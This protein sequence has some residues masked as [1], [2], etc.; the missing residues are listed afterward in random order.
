MNRAIILLA[1][2][3]FISA[4][5][6]TGIYQT[7][8]NNE[9]RQAEN[10]RH[11]L[12]EGEEFLSHNDPS[13]VSKA[14]QIF[15]ELSARIEKGHRNYF[16]VNYNL[17]LALEKKGEKKRALEK[18]RE[19]SSFSLP[20]LEENRLRY[21]LGNI[22]LMMNQEEEGK[23]LLKSVLSNSSDNILR[24]K[25][26]AAI[27]DYYYFKRNYNRAR[28]NYVLALKE[29]AGNVK[30]RI[31]W[32]RTLRAE[33]KDWAA[34]EVFDEYLAHDSIL[35]P[36]KQKSVKSDYKTS[37]YERAR[38]L[39]NKN[40]IVSQL[41]ILIKPY[42]FLLVARLKKSHYT[43]WPKVLMLWDRLINPSSI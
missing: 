28:K 27:A 33:G 32:G 21:S 6:A 15:T 4:G 19:L 42:L 11:K 41:I 24:A 17:A 10:F 16:Q 14:I 35:D 40:F 25:T 31:G 34:Y 23:G 13:S 8:L 43:I 38:D 22:L 9:Q 3:L 18:Y 2:F 29:D 39:F 37:V 20:K 5:V 30:A 7:M 1:G 36:G 26:L 12:N